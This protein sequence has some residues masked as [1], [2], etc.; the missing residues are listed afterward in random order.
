MPSYKKPSLLHPD[1]DPSQTVEGFNFNRNDFEDLID[2]FTP[3][4]DI[5]LLLGV[6]HAD[7][8]RFCYDI[9]N[10]DFKHTFE[11][12]LKRAELY[13]RKSMMMLSKA[14]NPSAIKVTS[15]HYVGLGSSDKQSEHI[16]FIGVMPDTQSDLQKL[17]SKNKE[18]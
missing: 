17:I 18:E 3:L 7:L 4:E 16:T 10:M 6:S 15:E 1:D 9:Y 11:S 12:L 5:P 14:G 8:D 13:Y 2:N